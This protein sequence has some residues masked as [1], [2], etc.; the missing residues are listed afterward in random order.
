M[1]ATTAPRMGALCR[2]P[3]WRRPAGRGAR[4]PAGA[5]PTTPS[6]SSPPADGR[7]FRYVDSE[8][9]LSDPSHAPAFAS[10][11]GALAAVDG[12]N[13]GAI[14]AGTLFGSPD[15]GVRPDSGALAASGAY[16]LVDAANAARFAPRDAS[17]GTLH[18]SDVQTLLSAAIAIAKRARAQIRRPLGSSAEV[19][20][21][22]VD[23]NG[24]ILG[25]AR[26]ADAPVFGIDV[27]VQKARTAMFFSLS[28]AAAELSSAPAAQYL[29][30]TTPASI[31][32]YVDAMRAFLGDPA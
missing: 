23:R 26:T 6:R 5:G 3:R 10:L 2:R 18:A 4:G 29:F 16:I 20:I 1:S 32:R 28:S 15:S 9:I 7:T 8:A 30:I 24:D 11:P 21:A 25:L 13:S 14:R 31:S 12:Y 17:D 19:T 27:A 22:I